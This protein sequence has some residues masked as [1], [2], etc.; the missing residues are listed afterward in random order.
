MKYKVP[1]EV[2]SIAHYIVEADSEDEAMD[3]A[4]DVGDCINIK[5]KQEEPVWA[6]EIKEK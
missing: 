3:I 6:K 4:T 1:V 2:T 5:P